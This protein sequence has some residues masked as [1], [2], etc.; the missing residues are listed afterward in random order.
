M[1]KL[2]YVFGLFV[3]VAG[4]S[5]CQSN[6]DNTQANQSCP[7]GTSYYNGAC[8]TGNG[9]YVQT[10]AYAYQ[11]GFYADTYSGTSSLRIINGA[12]MTEFF[13][14]GMGVCDRAGG[15]SGGTASCQAYVGGSMDMIIQ[16]PP[17]GGN[18]LLATFVA[19]PRL[20]PNFNYGYSL[21]SGW[22]ALGIALGYVTGVFLPDPRQY[23][24][25]YRNPLQLELAVSAINNSTGFSANGY[26]DYWSG[27]NRTKVTIEVPTGKMQDNQLPFIFKIG[28]VPAAQGV[29][30]RCQRTNCGI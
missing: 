19:Q 12:K 26:G 14:F 6:N 29:F 23:N 5:S 13:K 28:D 18:S 30:T 3:T 21:P 16:F 20:N 22:G 27:L 2:F 25:I 9:N 1:K 24:G 11:N 4:L 8:Y 10:A 17:N 15:A 7:A